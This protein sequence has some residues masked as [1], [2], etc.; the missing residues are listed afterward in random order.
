MFDDVVGALKAFRAAEQRVYSYSSAN[1]DNQ[2]LLFG[3]SEKGD[4]SEVRFQSMLA[5]DRIFFHLL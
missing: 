3:Y 5:F 1:V 4:L 2:K